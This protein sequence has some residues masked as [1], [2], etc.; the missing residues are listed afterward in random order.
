MEVTFQQSGLF[1]I[2][3]I[4]FSQMCVNRKQLDFYLS[5]CI[6]LVECYLQ[7]FVILCIGH[8]ENTGSLSY[9]NIPNAD[10][11]HYISK[12]HIISLKT[13]SSRKMSS[14]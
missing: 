4:Q 10:P 7:F 5:F 13:L 3:A 8:L 11:V 1:Y 12:N 14:T 6:Q 9:I 2:F